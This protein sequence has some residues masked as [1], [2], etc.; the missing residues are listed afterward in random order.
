MISIRLIAAAALLGAVSMPAAV[1]AQEYV[2]PQIW[3]N[4]LLG[5]S[6][7]THTRE[8]ILNNNGDRQGDRDSD[9]RVEQ[10]TSAECSVDALP[11][12]ERRAME[13]EYMRRLAAEGR[14]PADLWV[15]E[16]GR[17]FRERLTQQGVC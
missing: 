2:V 4:N 10:R 17:L 1:S 15:R 8:N 14:G 12:A 7:M 13:R 9:R 3:G 6:A 16:Q 11:A 5:Q